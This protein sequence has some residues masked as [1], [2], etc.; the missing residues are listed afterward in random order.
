MC[1]RC[2]SNTIVC[3]T[4]ICSTFM[5]IHTVDSHYGWCQFF[6]TC[7]LKMEK[8]T[9]V[10]K[11]CCWK[12]TKLMK[13]LRT[14]SCFAFIYFLHPFVRVYYE[15]SSEISFYGCLRIFA[16]DIQFSLEVLRLIKLKMTAKKYS[17]ALFF[18]TLRK[19]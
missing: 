17:H 1:R 11:M 9:L 3:R 15:F 13:N 12:Y 2:L 7:R 18:C 4:N 16:C 5:S 14:F 6:I 19:H 10:R 8:K